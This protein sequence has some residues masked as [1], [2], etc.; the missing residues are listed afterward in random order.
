MSIKVTWAV[1]FVIFQQLYK[2]ESALQVHCP[3]TKVLIITTEGLIVQVNVE[4]LA[5]FDCLRHAMDKVESRHIFVGHF[6][7]YAHHLRMIE[8]IDERQRSEE[9]TSE[10]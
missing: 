8:R 10:L 3:K 2:E 9:H 5:R 7:I 6:G 1:I 4:E